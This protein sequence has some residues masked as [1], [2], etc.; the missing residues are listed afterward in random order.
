[1][2]MDQQQ[3]LD[4]LDELRPT[5]SSLDISIFDEDVES[6]KDMNVRTFC[7]KVYDSI[8]DYSVNLDADP[9]ASGIQSL[10]VKLAKAREYANSA[11][12]LRIKAIR[13]VANLQESYTLL[14]ETIDDV[15]NTLKAVDEDC[16]K[17]RGYDEKKNIAESKLPNYIKLRRR[18]ARRLEE[19]K[20]CLKVVGLV[21]DSLTNT[22]EDILSQLGVIKQQLLIGELSLKIDPNTA[23]LIMSSSKAQVDSQISSLQEGPVTF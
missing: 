15:V 6:K 7:S 22:K 14:S 18:A 16:R 8:K 10:N 21:C 23:K 17:A 2:S 9:T 4:S 13:L 3:L 1:M 5:S 11:G 12:T 19:A 20:T